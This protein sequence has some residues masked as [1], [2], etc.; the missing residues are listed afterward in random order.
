MARVVIIGAGIVGLSV[1]RAALKKGHDA[2]V[3]EQGSAPNPQSASFDRHR[4]I[5]YHYGAAEGYARMVTDAFRSWDGVWS[6]FGHDHFEN[7]GAISI[8]L[9]AGDYT[10][11]T[12]AAFRSAGIPH[13]VLEREAVERLCPHLNLPEGSWGLLAFPG[14]PLFADAI[15]ADMAAW[16]KDHHGIIQH[17]TKVTRID[18]DAASVTTANETISGDFLVIA[19]GAWLPQLLDDYRQ[20][21]TFRQALCYVAPPE[22]YAA[23]WREAPAIVSI[24]DHSTYTL[25]DRR[26]AGLK[27]GYGPHRRLASPSEGFGWDISEADHV[28]G[29]F[30]PFLHDAK[31]YKPLRM[32]VGYYVMDDQRRFRFDHSGKSLVITNCDGQMFKFGPLIGENIIAAFEGKRSMPDLARW[33]AGYF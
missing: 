14:G 30:A 13:E 16:V 28:I 22:Q 23:A 2:I 6:D 7:T 8:S 9:V 26:G 1:A 20:S 5:R 33:A 3:L 10:D 17:H 12:R 25:P 32:Q 11:K 18:R 29:G 27:F 31:G 24:G 15:V 4:M 21:P 19:A